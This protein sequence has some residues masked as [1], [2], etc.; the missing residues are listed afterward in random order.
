MVKKSKMLTTTITF[1]ID[2]KILGIKKIKHSKP[3]HFHLGYSIESN[4]GDGE[5]LLKWTDNKM[6]KKV[7]KSVSKKVS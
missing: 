5:S 2:G 3:K 6:G 4:K 1:Y 7:K